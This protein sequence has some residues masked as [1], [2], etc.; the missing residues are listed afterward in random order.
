MRYCLTALDPTQTYC[1]R[2]NTEAQRTQRNT[3]KSKSEIHNQALLRSGGGLGRGQRSAC[4]LNYR[5]HRVHR[6][7]S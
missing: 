5:E 1:T 7:D 3:E 2:P 4:Y 6:G